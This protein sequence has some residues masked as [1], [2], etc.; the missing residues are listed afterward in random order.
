[1]FL[2]WL[3]DFVCQSHWM[4]VNKSKNLMALISH[5]FTYTFVLWLGG[6][7][8]LALELQD[9]ALEHMTSVPWTLCAALNGLLHFIV[10]CFT[11]KWTARLW[12]KN[13]VHNFFVVVGLDQ[14]IHATCLITTFNIFLCPNYL[15]WVPYWLLS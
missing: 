13:K 8:L 2:H 14:W 15:A 10:D 11:S 6:M 1:M 9:A 7:L 5:C 12:A 3:A 4:A